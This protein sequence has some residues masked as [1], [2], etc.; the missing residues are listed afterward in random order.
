MAD[1]TALLAQLADLGVKVP[2][3]V[4][5]LLAAHERITDVESYPAGP[6]LVAL[7]DLTAED[8]LRWT[9]LRTQ[10]EAIKDTR[11]QAADMIARQLAAVLAAHADD[12]IDQMR[13]AF[14]QAASHVTAARK[15][16]VTEHTTAS[17]LLDMPP[18]AVTA[19]RTATSHVATLAAIAHARIA[20][21]RTLGLTP[22]DDG[23]G[24]TYAVCFSTARR[25]WSNPDSPATW[26]R[27]A[28]SGLVLQHVADTEALTHRHPVFLAAP[29]DVEETT[30]TAARMV[31]R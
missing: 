20:M 12:L 10:L 17:D 16:N 2:A 28:D 1:V 29:D 14:D 21:S 3:E 27:L 7:E 6:G 18:K 9:L 23:T 26:L 15:L 8:I 13:P 22:E 19:W 25:G 24:S 4:A 31:A 30:E 5:P 11:V